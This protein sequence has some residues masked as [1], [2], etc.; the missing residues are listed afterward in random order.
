MGIGFSV[1]G[2]S[3]VSRTAALLPLG[4]LFALGEVV[5]RKAKE[6]LTRTLDNI[7]EREYVKRNPKLRELKVLA[8]KAGGRLMAPRDG[9]VRVEV[10]YPLPTEPNEHVQAQKGLYAVIQKIMSQSGHQLITN[11]DGIL[12]FCLAINGIDGYGISGVVPNYKTNPVRSAISGGPFKDIA[13]VTIG[14]DKINLTTVREAGRVLPAFV[15][16]LRY[17]SQARPNR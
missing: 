15:N 5:P 11:F 16:V 7:A 14:H 13:D 4:Y 3:Y 17:F 10:P 2:H 1:L 9:Y 12:P 8:E 6:F